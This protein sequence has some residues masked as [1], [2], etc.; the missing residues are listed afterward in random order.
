MTLN[1][2]AFAQDLINQEINHDELNFPK[3]FIQLAILL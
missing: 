2:F 1:K 3:I